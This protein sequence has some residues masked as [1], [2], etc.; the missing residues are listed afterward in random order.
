MNIKN[1]F[2]YFIML[3]V[4]MSFIVYGITDIAMD[5]YQV[6]PLTDEQIVERA[7]ELGMVDIKEA[8]IIEMDKKK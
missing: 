4:G 3:I 6:A 8:W 5:K 7:K 1:M 2:G